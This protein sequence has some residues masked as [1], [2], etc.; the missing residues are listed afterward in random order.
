M[1]ELAHLLWRKRRII[2]LVS[3]RRRASEE[4]HEASSAI[5]AEGVIAHS[6]QLVA[7]R[8]APEY[9]QRKGRQSA[10]W[11]DRYHT[12]AIEGGEHLRARVGEAG[13]TLVRGDCGWQP[14]FRRDGKA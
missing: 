5:S 2:A 9:I 11:E 10:F 1:L 7:R 6:M 4:I 12:T 13:R 8:A 3:E 14:S